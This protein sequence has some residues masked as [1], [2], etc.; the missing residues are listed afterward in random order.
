LTFTIESKKNIII[1]LRGYHMVKFNVSDLDQTLQELN[2]EGSFKAS[3]VTAQN[4]FLIASAISKG[5]DEDIVAA[6]GPAIYSTVAQ[7]NNEIKL[8]K[9]HDI[10]VMAEKG[11][12]VIKYLYTEKGGEYILAI[13]AP[14]NANWQ[15][16]DISGL[17]E[18]IRDILNFLETE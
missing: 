17:I 7:V 13:I 5:T 15:G 9:T 3:I 6:T 18:K 2:K 12:L 16:K 4:G 8:G 14:P 11:V 1:N 10:I